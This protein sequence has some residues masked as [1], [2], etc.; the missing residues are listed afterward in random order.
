MKKLFGA[1]QMPAPP[2]PPVLAAPAPVNMQPIND[3]EGVAQEEANRRRKA[4]KAGQVE[5]I[6][7]S[8][9]GL[10]GQSTAGRTVLGE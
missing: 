6:I 5:T 4:L 10:G 1:P 7:T 8:G 9:Q 2:P 3:A